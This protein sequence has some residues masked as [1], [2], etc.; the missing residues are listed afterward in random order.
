MNGL[1]PLEVAIRRKADEAIADAT[2]TELAA[3]REAFVAGLVRVNPDGSFTR[4]PLPKSEVPDDARRLLNKLVGTR[5]LIEHHDARG[6][7]VEIARDTLLRVWSTLAV[8]LEEEK[9]FLLG[10][11]RIE[12][13]LADYQRRKGE[14]RT[15][16]LLTGILLDRARTWVDLYPARFSR[17]ETAYI[18]ASARHWDGAWGSSD[19]AAEIDAV[20]EAEPVSARVA[21]KPAWR[22]SVAELR[23]VAAAAAILLLAGGGGWL[24]LGRVAASWDNAKAQTQS[25]LV[26]AP[27]IAAAVRQQQMTV[28]TTQEGRPALTPVS[29]DTIGSIGAPAQPPAATEADAG[30][31]LSGPEQ[32]ALA[33]SLEQSGDAKLKAGD[34]A[35]ALAD[36]ATAMPIV[37]EHATD[38]SNF[39][40]QST[41]ASLLA[42]TADAK[43]AMGDRPGALADLQ[44]TLPLRRAVAKTM[45]SP[46]ARR[47]LIVDLERLGKLDRDAGDARGSGEADEEVVATLR[48]LDHDAGDRHSRSALAAGLETLGDA[49]LQVGD[50]HA[51]RDAYDESV[52]ILRHVGASDPDTRRDLAG[53]LEKLGTA[54]ARAGDVAGARA[55]RSEAVELLRDAARDK[56]NMPA[57]RRLADALEEA[58]DLALANGDPAALSAYS[59]EAAIR[60]DLA[61]AGI[62]TVPAPIMSVP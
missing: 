52:A 20:V 15:E 6:G 26:Q 45:P 17:E 31:N 56:T 21:A 13:A 54:K 3:L 46:K 39:E 1:S 29:L 34:A 59:E 22:L 5:L 50:V 49:K 2:S 40:A 7:S 60:R 48:A 42:D 27:A 35:G 53:D 62:A 10:K 28:A 4:H 37:R 14:A 30:P 24:V 9:E 33:A 41:L 23:A 8:W 57:R 58:G 16:A 32:R 38:K 61:A 47:A 55:A 11:T 12:R 43:L 19:G 44:E 25:G 18:A 36:F 51:A